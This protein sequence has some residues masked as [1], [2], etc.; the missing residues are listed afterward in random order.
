MRFFKY[1]VLIFTSIISFH[2]F[3]IEYEYKLKN[4]SHDVWYPT[5][6]AACESGIIPFGFNNP[7][8][9][10]SVY[11]GN[12]CQFLGNQRQ[13][14]EAVVSRE[15]NKCPAKYTPLVV[16][17]PKG[18]THV[19]FRLCKD[20]CTYEGSGRITEMTNYDNTILQA[21]GDS[22]NCKNEYK[23]DPPPKC[24]KTDPYGECYVPPDDNCVRTSNGSIHCPDNSVPP[25][26]ETCN[27]AD[28]CKRPPQGCGPGYVPG[29]FNGQQLC[30][31]SGPNTPKNPP[32]PDKPDDPNNCMNGGSYCPQPPNNTTCPTGYTE[33]S[34]NGSKICVKDNPDPTIPNPNDPNN[35]GGGD[36]GGGASEPSGGN[37]GGTGGSINLKPV[38]DAIKALRDSL[39]SSLDAISKKLSSLVDGQKESNEHL[40]NIKSES[41]KTNEKLDTSNSHLDKI[42]EATTATSEAIGETNDKLDRVFSD[43]GKEQIEQLGEQS[44]DSRLTAAETEMTSKLQQ[45]AN[46]LSYSSSHACISD[47]TVTNIPHF[48]SMTVPLSKWCDLLALVKL[49]LKLAVLMLAL[50][51]IDATVRAF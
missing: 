7:G 44:T 28:Y 13:R 1:L 35:S 21:T 3:G 30:V 48:G 45:F 17:L 19:P 29:S 5:M 6:L 46:T 38:I 24:D 16:W 9:Q 36:D 47:F 22:V 33:T 8:D 25:D 15:K 50:K 27:G 11:S 12:T 10:V 39:L 18:T 41:V 20:G 32:D 14:Y 40:K 34:Y 23:D 43:E 26:N 49:L 37:D 51:M 42:E 4:I 2:A 31:R